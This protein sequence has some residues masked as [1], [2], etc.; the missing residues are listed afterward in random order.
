MM[1]VSLGVIPRT[2]NAV[3]TIRPESLPLMKPAF[4]QIFR[5]RGVLS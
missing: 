5:L 3:H 2:M 4:I 1:I